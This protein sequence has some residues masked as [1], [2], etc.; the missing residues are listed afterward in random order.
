MD[1]KEQLIN[2]LRN[3]AAELTKIANETPEMEKKAS[4]DTVVSSERSDYMNGVMQGL[5]LE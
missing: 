1:N 2:D 5:G 3:C 4:A